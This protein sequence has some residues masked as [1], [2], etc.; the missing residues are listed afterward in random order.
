MKTKSLSRTR[1]RGRKPKKW[2]VQVTRERKPSFFSRKTKDYSERRP[3]KA[4]GKKKKIEL[5]KE[6][7]KGFHRRRGLGSKDK[8]K[9]QEKTGGPQE[10][11]QNQKEKKRRSDKPF[12]KMGCLNSG[13]FVGHDITVTGETLAGPLGGKNTSP[14]IRKE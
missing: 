4:R 12:L 2:P 1:E 14:L 6:R 11:S 13:R 5:L 7:E 8:E 10:G 9:L 3:S